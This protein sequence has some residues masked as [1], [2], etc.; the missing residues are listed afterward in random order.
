MLFRLAQGEAARRQQVYLSSIA[1][2]TTYT[3]GVYSWYTPRLCLIY[4]LRL[5]TLA[6][7][8]ILFPLLLIWLTVTRIMLR[9]VRARAPSL[10]TYRRTPKAHYRLN[11]GYRLPS[12]IQHHSICQRFEIDSLHRIPPSQNHGSLIVE[13][14]QW[15]ASWQEQTFHICTLQSQGNQHS[16]I[17]QRHTMLQTDDEYDHY[18]IRLLSRK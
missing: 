12:S 14:L 13:K 11:K 4:V 15:R 10:F 3:H 1:T 9:L 17:K 16:A 6:D 7:S 18:E 2:Y 5:F 8:Y